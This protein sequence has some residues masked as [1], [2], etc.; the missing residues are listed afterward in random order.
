MRLLLALAGGGPATAAQLAARLP[1]VPPA[2]LYRHLGLLRRGGILAVAEERRVRGAVE[3]RYVL[4]PGAAS[5][6]PADLAG[7]SRDDHLRWFATFL[8]GLLDA[9]ARYLDRGDPD[10]ARDGVGYRQVILHLS[11]PELAEMSAALNTMLVRFAGQP[12]AEGR[13]PRLFATVLVPAAAV[14]GPADQPVTTE[15]SA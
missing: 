6:G 3:R 10:L 14:A 5:L 4:P 15:E 13:T 9:F 12:P 1:D 8:A 2:T 7:A 11:D